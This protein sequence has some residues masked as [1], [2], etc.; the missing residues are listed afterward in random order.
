MFAA[1]LLIM[2]VVFLVLRYTREANAE[3]AILAFMSAL[4]MF[5]GW[6]FYVF[7]LSST[8]TSTTLVNAYNITTANVPACTSTACNSITET[9]IH[10]AYNITITQ[11]SKQPSI[12]ISSYGFILS[13]TLVIFYTILMILF[14]VRDVII[15][16]S[17]LKA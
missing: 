12:P 16:R 17:G 15:L 14:M 4:F 9:Q 6:Y 7:P 8:T 11:I 5:V 2:A 1:I 3:K 13:L 10:P